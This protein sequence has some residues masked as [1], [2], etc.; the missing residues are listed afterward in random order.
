LGIGWERDAGPHTIDPE[1]QLIIWNTKI[2]GHLIPPCP[3]V[4]NDEK[5]RREFKCHELFE[6]PKLAYQ[7]P[8]MTIKKGPIEPSDSRHPEPFPGCPCGRNNGSSAAIDYPWSK[9]LPHTEYVN[10]EEGI[11]HG[12]INLGKDSAA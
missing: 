2:P 10:K 3:V 5:I 11:C 12:P 1:T 9:P 4:R 7:L 6:I 8:M